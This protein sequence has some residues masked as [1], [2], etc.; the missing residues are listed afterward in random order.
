MTDATLQ[1]KHI[2]SAKKH[3]VIFHATQ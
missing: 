1:H 3:Y 2:R